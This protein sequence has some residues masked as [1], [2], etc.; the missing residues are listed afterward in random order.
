MCLQSP[1]WDAQYFW[2][3]PQQHVKIMIDFQGRYFETLRH[4][5]IWVRLTCLASASL[6]R[7]WSSDWVLFTLP[8]ILVTPRTI[9]AGGEERLIYSQGLSQVL[10]LL[11]VV[12]EA[13]VAFSREGVLV[14]ANS[15]AAHVRLLIT[16]LVHWE[17]R[18]D[19]IKKKIPDLCW[20]IK[21]AM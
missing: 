19:R 13:W 16:E 9:R 15:R 14:I 21:I 18:S 4:F 17:P 11:G 8:T 1:C 20:C 3:V 6:F 10:D 5:S 12:R 7:I 2:L